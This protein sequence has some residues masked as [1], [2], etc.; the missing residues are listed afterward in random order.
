LFISALDAWGKFP[1]GLMQG[2]IYW[3]GS[4]YECGHHLRGLNNSVVEQPF[5]TRTCVISNGISISAR[6][7]YGICV[8]QSCNANDVVNYINRRM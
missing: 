8:P 5:R 7:V 4:V 2:N 3:V 6:P 1:S